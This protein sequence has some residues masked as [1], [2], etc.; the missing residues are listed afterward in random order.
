MF[1]RPSRVCRAVDSTLTVD[2]R[3]CVLTLIY[4]FYRDVWLARLVPPDGVVQLSVGPGCHRDP[5]GS[6]HIRIWV[7]GK[8]ISVSAW[9]GT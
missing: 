4:H 3:F 8:L 1:W 5:H 7:R 2:F 6:Q 9:A